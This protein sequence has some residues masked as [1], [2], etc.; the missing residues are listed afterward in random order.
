[1]TRLPLS[2][3]SEPRIEFTL[4]I[5]AGSSLWQENTPPGEDAG[6]I[7][8][9]LS[10]PVWVRREDEWAVRH[11]LRFWNRVSAQPVEEQTG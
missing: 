8:S 5:G 6:Q 11:L 1:M 9:D 3:V 10:F 2:G 7:A 4:K